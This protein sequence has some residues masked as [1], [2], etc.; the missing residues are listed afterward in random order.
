M[1]KITAAFLTVTTSLAVTVP[2]LAAGNKITEESGNPAERSVEIST[3][4]KPAYAVTIPGDVDVVFDQTSTGFG[5]VT[6]EEA[7]L[8]PGYVVRVKL[9]S[10][11]SLKN[12]ADPGKTIPYSI[13]ADGAAYNI[14]EYTA[15]GQSTDLTIDIAQA[16]WDEAYAG[17]YSDTVNFTISYVKAGIS[18]DQ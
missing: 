5:S 15:D 3:S 12:E 4:I 1:K 2:V 11:G 10:S 8:E 6:L 7:Q 13:N 16:A 9:D 17:D 18:A 14:G